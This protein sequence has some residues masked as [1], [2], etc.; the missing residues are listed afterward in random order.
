MK[1]S[2]YGLLVLV[3]LATSSPTLV[4]A[5]PDDDQGSYQIQ[6]QQSGTAQTSVPTDTQSEQ[7]GN[8]EAHT[9]FSAFSSLV[10]YGTILS[11]LVVIGYS[12]WKVYKVR[13]KVVP[14]NLV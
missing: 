10:L 3:I 12:A 7:K 2:S 6:G 5:D 8:G 11:I 4:L 9:I 13:R 14:K 1:I